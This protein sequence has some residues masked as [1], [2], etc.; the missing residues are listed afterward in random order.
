[1]NANKVVVITGAGKG[2][3]K[4][5]A[6]AFAKEKCRLVLAS[7]TEA[8]LKAVLDSCSGAECSALRTDVSK[9][10]DVRALADF[11]AKKYGRIDLWINNAGVL[12]RG[13][14]ET[15]TAE[16]LKN[17]FEVN[18]YGTIYGCIHA[19][20]HMK[21]QKSGHI[22]NVI[23]TTAKDGKENE[24]AYSASKKAVTGFD[25]AFRK[26]ALP[27]RVK[28]TDFNPGGMGT[29]LFRGLGV[30]TSGFMDPAELAKVMVA[31]ASLPDNA[32]CTDISIRR[33]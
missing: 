18:T 26:E 28:V 23:S 33:M 29:E 15:L 19:F 1:M 13:P 27:Y 6:V 14:A 24:A 31:I 22:I 11:A 25:E 4:A 9:E 8:D 12:V 5:L 2:L 16:Q 32:V 3:G 17:V 20:R 21:Q 7:R 10:S 30:D